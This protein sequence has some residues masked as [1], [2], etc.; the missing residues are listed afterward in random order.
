MSLVSTIAVTLGLCPA[1]AQ[2]AGAEAPSSVTGHEDVL[3]SKE[4]SQ[5]GWAQTCAHMDVMLTGW[6]CVQDLLRG[7]L[8]DHH[9]CPACGHICPAGEKKGLKGQDHALPTAGQHVGIG[10]HGCPGRGLGF[11]VPVSLAVGQQSWE[12][13]VPDGLEP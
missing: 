7:I 12:P 13:I 2:L 4:V 8:P 10:C 9:S 5:E 3:M 11:S 1:P 6:F